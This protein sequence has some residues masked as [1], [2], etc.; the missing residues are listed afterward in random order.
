MSSTQLRPEISASSRL[1]SVEDRVV[2]I[3]VQ[4]QFK[5][6]EQIY[7]QGDRR[8]M[9]L[10]ID[11]GTVAISRP[12]VARPNS[13]IRIADAGEY[14]GLGCLDHHSENARAIT[15]AGVTCVSFDE[16]ADLAQHDPR[17]RDMQADANERDFEHRKD[18]LTTA[19]C[20]TPAESVAAL[21]V[22]ISRLNAQEGR[23]PLIVADSLTCGVAAG[24]LDL[25]IDALAKALILL[26]RH[27]VIV[28]TE[29]GAIRIVSLDCLDRFSEDTP[30]AAQPAARRSPSL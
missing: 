16:F 10:R 30:L 29:D 25:D 28:S 22:C 23:D 3:I 27:G 24:L 12:R 13:V 14:I 21:L 17:L 26:E 9:V 15:D 4:K 11:L 2:R 18:E 5:T 6:G 7:R 1:S 20:S 8:D 19:R